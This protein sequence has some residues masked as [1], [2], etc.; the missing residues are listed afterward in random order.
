MQ[1]D[2]GGTKEREGTAGS[3]LDCLLTQVGGGGERKHRYRK[4]K[5]SHHVRLL[6]HCLRPLQRLRRDGCDKLRAVDERNA[7]LGSQLNGPQV[8]GLKH[9]RRELK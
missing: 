9:L 4:G 7:F 6:S 1:S 3:I 5:G 8:V 2:L